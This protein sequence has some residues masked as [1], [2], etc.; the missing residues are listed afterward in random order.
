MNPADADW[1][2]A[3][4][5]N[6]EVAEKGIQGKKI[7]RANAEFVRASRV[8]QQGG[9]IRELSGFSGLAG[10]TGLGS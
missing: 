9:G 6:G 4:I 8:I 1:W 7:L 3:G 10:V 2:G 5:E